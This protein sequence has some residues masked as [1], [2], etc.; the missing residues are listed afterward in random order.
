MEHTFLQLRV[1]IQLVQHVVLLVVVRG[2]H[3]EDDDVLDGL[4]IARG[5]V[6]SR[7]RGAKTSQLTSFSFSGSALTSSVSQTSW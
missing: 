7:G 5:S 6:Q 4:C 3:N 1:G 2:E